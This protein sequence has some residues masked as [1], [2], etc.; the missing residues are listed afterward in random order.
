VGPDLIT[1]TGASPT[2][3]DAACWF[4]ILIVLVAHAT[5]FSFKT[6]KVCG[7]GPLLPDGAFLKGSAVDLSSL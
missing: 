6:S 1:G 4:F 2:M 5:V 3:R 7:Y